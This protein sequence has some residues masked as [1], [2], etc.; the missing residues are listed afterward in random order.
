M[1]R[2][3]IQPGNTLAHVNTTDQPILSEDVVVFGSRIGVAKTNI[4]SGETG[5][6]EMEGVWALPKST[7]AFEVGTDVFWSGEQIVKTA[8]E[9]TT[10]AGYVFEAAAA[11]DESVNVKLKG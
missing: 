9:T 5:A 6:V 2:T 8:T 11:G 4:L 7:A 10:P 3:Y 1:A